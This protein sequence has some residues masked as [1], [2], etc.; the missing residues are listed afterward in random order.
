M[1]DTFSGHYPIERRTGEIERLHVQS[2]AFARDVEVMLDLIGVHAGWSCLDLGCGPGGITEPLA[3]RVGP[4]G[5]VIG[6]D[7]DAA[8]LAHARARAPANAEFRQGDAYAADLPDGSFD[9]VHMRFLASTVR[10]ARARDRRRRSG[11]A[12]R[13]ARLRCRSRI[14]PRSTVTRRIRRGRP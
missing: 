14:A 11:C 6:L 1:S 7:K 13:A 10:R 8:F 4:N 3:R 9:L 12:V 5:R 2:A